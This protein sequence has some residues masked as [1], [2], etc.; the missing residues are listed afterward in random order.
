[1]AV[2]AP[3]RPRADPTPA[4][5]TVLGRLARFVLRHRRVVIIFWLVVFLAGGT[6]AGKVSNRL[7]IDFSLP[8]QPGYETGV[9]ILHLY[10]SG[11][12]DV[13]SIL[14]VTVP[15]GQS[16]AGDRTTIASA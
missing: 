6:A 12:Q 10:G 2:T 5:R 16:V 9:K 7:K 8:G 3:P 15:P 13:P 1:M 11:G 4:P 14:V